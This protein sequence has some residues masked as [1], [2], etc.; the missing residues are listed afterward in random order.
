M[1][2]M[3]IHENWTVR[4]VGDLAQVPPEIRDRDIPAQVP[5]C[6]HTDL[7]EASL[8]PDPY[9]DRNE[10]EVQWI[11]ETDWKY[12]CRFDASAVEE[13][14]TVSLLFE[15]LDTVAD[16]ALNGHAVGHAENMHH[17]HRFD[18][19]A[20]LVEG[21][22]ELT[23]LFTSAMK[24]MRE[25]RDRMGDLPRTMPDPY[26][27]IRK[28][29]CNVGWDWGPRLTTVGV[30]CPA[31][32]DR[33][34]DG[35]RIES[36]RPLMKEASEQ[37][38]VVD[39]HVDIDPGTASALWLKGVLTDSDGNIVAEVTRAVS[40]SETTLI[41]E[42]ENPHLWWPVGY[43]DQPL[44]ELTVVLETGEVELDIWHKKTGLRSLRLNTDADER[45]SK[46]QV[47]INGKPVFCHGANWI[48]DDCFITRVT[49][50]R[51][52]ERLEQAIGANMNMLRVWGGGIY[53]QP[54]F[55]ELC[56]ELGILVWQDFLFAC[57]AY[58]E[59]KPFDAYIEAE[60][61]YQVAR[62]SRHPSLVVWNGNNE[63]IWG[64]FDWNWEEIIGDRTW[65]NGFYLD[66][67][68]RVVAEVDPSRPYWAGSP[69]S[70]SMDIHPLDEGHGPR[71]E[72][73]V[74]NKTDYPVH[75][76]TTPR[77]V[78]EFGHQAP[79]TFATL[80]TAIPED[81]R[82]SVSES[83]T[84]HQRAYDGNDKL[85][86][87]LLEHFAMPDD[88]DDWHYLTQVNQA[89]SVGTGVEWYRSR[90]PV[91]MGTLYWQI[92][93]CW[94]V[95]SWA[96]IDGYGRRKPLWYATRRFYAPRLLTIQPEGDGLALFAVND[97]D[98]SWTGSGT[99]RGMALA[100]DVRDEKVIA[101]NVPPRTCVMVAGPADMPALPASPTAEF[102]VA[103]CGD[104]R[105]FWYHDIDRNLEYPEPDYDA[106]IETCD[107]GCVLTIR[108][109]TFLR[110]LTVYADK[111]MPDAE[112]SDQLITL[113]PGD[114]AR[115]TVSRCEAMLV[116]QMSQRPV[117]M[118]VNSFGKAW[119]D[120]RAT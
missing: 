94:P 46:F 13:N 20:T 43:G 118:C 64:Y 36:V 68:P 88:F 24:Y 74:W 14:E 77:F 110:D 29:A 85:H 109:R 61:R 63:N 17:A 23:I 79:P 83:M 7:L 3:S 104:D 75:R 16:I 37:R 92:N 47:E 22:N 35:A 70:G 115:I 8:I 108:A 71:H 56:D 98:E 95:T 90:M 59:E 1:Q 42:V 49:R 52:R 48:P 67:L 113:L 96:C 5:G 86:T 31:Y 117:L 62:L 58:P 53:E 100:G 25:M 106:S 6:F 51:Y 28:M 9:I 40:G 116:D 93:D 82:S 4:A 120:G 39:V 107:N 32:L 103:E 76:D 119:S 18:V 112:V 72:W 101:L 27:F 30:W 60:A 50:E 19:T 54:D 87:R 81:Q 2:R 33:A 105:G 21:A 89:R 38:A 44:Y 41:L 114:T 12:S 65:G 11:G 99:I 78:S 80:R 102:I 10:N 26:N 97:S 34:R 15:G 45:G 57:A 84:H 73:D 55:Y 66:L 69:Y 111:M 91:C